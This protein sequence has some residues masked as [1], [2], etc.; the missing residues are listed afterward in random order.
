[1]SD[2]SEIEKSGD[3]VLTLFMDD[4][5][6]KSGIFKICNLKARRDK[7]FDPFEA[8]GNL[9]NKRI[10]PKADLKQSDLILDEKTMLDLAG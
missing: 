10:F 4:A 7:L 9:A 5:M 2:S 6:R 1:M 3:V 8:C